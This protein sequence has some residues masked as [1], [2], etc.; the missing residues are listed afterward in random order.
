MPDALILEFAG[1]SDAGYAAVNENLG[2]DAETG[3]GDW[4]AGKHSRRVR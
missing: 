4:P 1:L 3:Q 2:I